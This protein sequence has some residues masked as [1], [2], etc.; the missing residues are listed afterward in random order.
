MADVEE[1]SRERDMTD[2]LPL[3]KRGALVAQNPQAF[4]SIPDLEPEE[5]EYLEYEITHK[6]KQ[7]LALYATIITCSVGAAVQYVTRF[8]LFPQLGTHHYFVRGWDQT[9]SNG[10][11][12]SF[13]D[14]FGI[15]SKSTRDTFLV[16]LVNAGPYIA[17]AFMLVILFFYQFFFRLSLFI[18]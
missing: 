12:L 2:I 5:R 4:E 15:G 18:F 13:P 11:N 10:A 3:L 8:F 17:S 16:G 1:F 6:W 9:G 14:A 7:P